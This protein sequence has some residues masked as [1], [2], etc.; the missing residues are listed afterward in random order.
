[1][2]VMKIHKVDQ[3]GFTLLEL[4]IVV[5]IIGILT[6]I[7][8]P[9]YKNYVTKAKITEATSELSDLRIKMEQFYQD[10]RTYVNGPCVGASD[11]A[12][13]T[14]SCG[15][16]TQ[17]NYTITA[18]GIGSVTGYNYSINAANAR[19]STTPKGGTNKTC[20]AIKLDGGC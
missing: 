1:M 2:F 10:N 7:V 19:L 14:I 15:T 5:A 9:S 8:L 11:I 20:W 18:Q 13:F 4:M 16:P 3:M 12:S 6:S 17:N